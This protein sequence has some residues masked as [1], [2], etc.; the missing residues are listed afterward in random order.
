MTKNDLDPTKSE[1]EADTDSDEDD[2]VK[3][4]GTILRS[5]S[6]YGG[7]I[8]GAGSTAADTRN[9]TRVASKRYERKCKCGEHTT[10]IGETE[11]SNCKRQFLTIKDLQDHLAEI[12]QVCHETGCQNKY[13]PRPV[14]RRRLDLN[15]LF[16]GETHESNEETP[17]Y[18]DVTA[19]WPRFLP[20]TFRCL[21]DIP[22]LDLS[23][24]AQEVI[25]EKGL[26]LKLCTPGYLEYYIKRL[27]VLVK[28]FD[29]PDLIDENENA[30]TA[31]IHQ[32]DCNQ[33]NPCKT[34][35]KIKKIVLRPSS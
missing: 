24:E 19:P 6:K 29:L 23:N 18:S 21:V 22:K 5:K 27:P 1:G 2:E 11:C 3:F 12:G 34:C 25:K 16:M 33:D 15:L 7:A 14:K 32:K 17:V 9:Q 20:K 30:E 35:K 28:G 13:G 31:E 8:D 10:N 4:I 26:N